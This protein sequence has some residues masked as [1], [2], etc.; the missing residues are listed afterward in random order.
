MDDDVAVAV[1][2][3]LGDLDDK[4]DLLRE[5]N[6]TLEDIA[7]AVFRAWFVDFEPVRAKAAGAA[8]F[9]GMHQELFDQLPN[10]FTPSELG[11]IPTGWTVGCV[12]DV[13]GTS[14]PRGKSN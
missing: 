2:K 10:S 3:V 1:A 12:G 6:R 4:I 7:R 5:M 9:R 8:S 13:F 14:A 11:D